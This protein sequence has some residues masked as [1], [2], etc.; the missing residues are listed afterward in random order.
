LYLPGLLHK[1]DVSDWLDKH[2]HTRGELIGEILRTPEWGALAPFPDLDIRSIPRRE[3]LYKPLYIR[4]FVTGRF[5]PGGWAKTSMSV[6]DALSMTTGRNLT[7]ASPVGKLV[8]SYW[9]GEDPLDELHRRFAAAMKHY[10]I[11]YDDIAGRLFIRSGRDWPIIVA[12]EDARKKVK[13][14]DAVIEN[15]IA[16][17]RR[18]H[19]DA[20]IIDPLISCHRCDE[21][22]QGA[23][24]MIVKDAWGKVAVE[25]NC[26]V[27]L[28]HHTR[29]IR[30]GENVG[31]D[32]GRGASSLNAALRHVQ[33]LNKMSSK[34][35]E[36]AQIADVDRWSYLRADDNGKPNLVPPQAATWYHLA[37]VNLGNDQ[38]S[39]FEHQ[40]DNVQVI[41]LW[42]YPVVEKPRV[43]GSDIR[44]AQDKIAA[45]G[46]WRSSSQSKKEPW[47]GIPIARALGLKL[48][49]PVQKRAVTWLIHDWVTAGHLKRVEGEDEHR[50]RREYIEVDQL[51]HGAAPDSSMAEGAAP[52]SESST[53][54]N[55]D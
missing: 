3:W 8:V 43:T 35:A 50:E 18:N 41:E 26:G 7:G 38:D 16:N 13:M 20:V 1:Q 46:P 30:A 36:A 37:S 54:E 32:D 2:G 19:V 42:N 4:K 40:G 55:E 45:G 52:Y 44:L 29:K 39:G 31:V 6:V 33:A 27:N 21:N 14:N 23:M 9:N 48:E 24:D 5:A 15:M 25:A 10:E 11:S 17:Y 53:A 51:V 49:T 22:T 12:E 47:V 34:E 28:A